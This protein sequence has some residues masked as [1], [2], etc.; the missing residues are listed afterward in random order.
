MTPLL[1]DVTVPAPC[2]LVFCSSQ[3]DSLPEITSKEPHFSERKLEL[4]P[5]SLSDPSSLILIFDEHPPYT[6]LAHHGRI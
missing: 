4:L 6:P 3:P 2:V 5:P 1:A